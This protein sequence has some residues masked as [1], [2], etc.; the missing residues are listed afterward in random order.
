MIYGHSRIGQ[1]VAV[2][3]PT[4]RGV[5]GTIPTRID[6]VIDTQS[7]FVAARH[8]NLDDPSPSK[9]STVTPTASRSA[10]SFALCVAKCR[11]ELT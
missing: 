5:R 2:T 8:V 4:A 7:S 6:C 1:F 3:L 10:A 9:S 11:D